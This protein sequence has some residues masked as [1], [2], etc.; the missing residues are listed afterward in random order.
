MALYLVERTDD[1]DYEENRAAVVR[2]V[3]PKMA[4]DFAAAE[5]DGFVSHGSSGANFTV[6]K[7]EVTGPT[8]AILVDNVGA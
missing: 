2:A 5:I 4:Y 3:S 6:K 7:I 8:V 1:P